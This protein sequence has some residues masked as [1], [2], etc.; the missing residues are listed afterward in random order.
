MLQDQ[1]GIKTARQTYIDKRG[2]GVPIILERSEADSG[3]RP[4]YRLLGDA[5]LVLTILPPGPTCQG[6]QAEIRRRT[7]PESEPRRLLPLVTTGKPVAR[8]AA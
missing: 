1:T 6:M 4:E 2:D 3:R 7:V 8:H 5:Q